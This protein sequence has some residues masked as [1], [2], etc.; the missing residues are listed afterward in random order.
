MASPL[1]P[2]QAVPLE[3]G[4]QGNTPSAQQLAGMIAQARAKYL[5]QIGVDPYTQSGAG[6]VVTDIPADRAVTPKAP[7]DGGASI[8]D[9]TSLDVADPEVQKLAQ[10]KAAADAANA[11]A[12]QANTDPNSPSLFQ[13]GQ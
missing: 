5:N 3:Q 1:P 8:Q 11:K 12:A 4:A 10:L 6:V 13:Q 7:S 9:G 2:E